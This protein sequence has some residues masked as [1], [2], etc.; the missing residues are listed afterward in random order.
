MNSFLKSL[1]MKGE[2]NDFNKNDVSRIA[3]LTQRSNQFNLRT[4]RYNEDDIINIS[5][6]ENYLKYTVKINDKFGEY[7]LISIVILEKLSD[8]EYFIDT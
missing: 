1:E 2:I 3:Q 7:G 5:S 4:I 6:S 8:D